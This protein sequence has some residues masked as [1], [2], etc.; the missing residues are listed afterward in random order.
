MKHKKG[1]T[2]IEIVVSVALIAVVM[3]FLFQL[4]TDV[5]FEAQHPAYANE[6]QMVRAS[7]MRRIQQDF[8]SMFLDTVS[9][10]AAHTQITFDF[11]DG[12]KSVTKKLMLS[13]TEINY[14]N[15]EKW[16]V[17]GQEV[18]LDL[19]NISIIDNRNADNS[20]CSTRHNDLLNV[21]ESIC[22]SYKYIKIVIPVENG[23]SENIIDDI[24]LFYIGETKVFVPDYSSRTFHLSYHNDAGSVIS[25]SRISTKHP[26]IANLG[27]LS[28]SDILYY[29]DQLEIQIT[30]KPNY[31]LDSYSVSSYDSL[32]DTMPFTI[33]VSDN[34][35]ITSTS[36]LN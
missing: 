5:E 32:P 30:A 9:L 6:N 12:D 24:E 21:D 15:E 18:Y 2:L 20:L 10:N 29:D 31:V 33:V 16:T 35:E 26:G 36:H 4:L 28:T 13:E 3:L 23:N 1:F 14:N 27:S 17:K 22:P 11:K 25:V 19:N 7:V 34:V 8:T